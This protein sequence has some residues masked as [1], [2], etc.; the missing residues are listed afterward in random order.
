[1]NVAGFE[2]AEVFATLVSILREHVAERGLERIVAN[3]AAI[4]TEI[5]PD[6][7]RIADV[8]CS[9]AARGRPGK[10][11][12]GRPGVTP[13]LVFEVLSPSNRWPEVLEKVGEY[14]K[15]GVAVV[16]VLDPDQRA[17]TSTLPTT[18]RSC[19]TGR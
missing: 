10:R 11:L 16:C 8:A 9:R 13:D 3:D 19:C 4:V 17:Y 15:V 12:P 6:T 18:H 2:Y 14:L 1:M 5:N 7:V